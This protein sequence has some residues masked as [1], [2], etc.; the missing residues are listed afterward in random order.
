M[1]CRQVGVADCWRLDV[2]RP[3]PGSVRLGVCSLFGHECHP[4]R[5]LYRSGLYSLL[6]SHL[7]GDSDATT[8]AVALNCRS[9]NTGRA[10]SRRR[11]PIASGGEY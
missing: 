8:V 6:D 4:E 7:D 2:G 3:H 11:V 1:R 5:R 10:G 9:S